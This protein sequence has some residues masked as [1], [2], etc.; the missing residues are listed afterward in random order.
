MIRK[1]KT[2]VKKGLGNVEII[3]KYERRTKLQYKK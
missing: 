1:S 2:K 3:Q